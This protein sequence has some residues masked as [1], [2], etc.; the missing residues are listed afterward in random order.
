MGLQASTAQIQEGRT[1]T[2]T[3]PE[4]DTA[5]RRR[6]VGIALMCG[7]VAFFASLDACAKT[8]AR[9]GVDPL[10]TTFMRYAASVAMISLFINPVATPG[11]MK[12]RR[13]GL[14]IVRSL[15]LFASTALNFVALRYLQMAETISIQFAA[16]LTVAL[17]AGPLLGEWS[18]RARLA[19]IGVGF[20][21]VLVIVRPGVG[22]MHPAALLCVANVVVYAFYAILTRKL[23]AHDSTA[24]TMFYTG[25]AGVALMAPL[26]PWIW[27]NPSE[28][29][30]W[31]LLLGVALFGTLGHWLLVMAHARAPA[32]VLAPFIYTQ[33]LWSVT[34]GFL[35]FGDLPSRWTIVGAMIVVGSGLYLLAQDTL[36]R[37]ARR[38]AA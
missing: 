26:L 32:N 31:A 6:I 16:P 28:L 12:S 8:L 2:R 35:L 9:G 25:L 5:R 29:S 13:L 4:P 23:A 3:A 38:P 24:T 36:R 30:H 14:Q 37:E 1:E 18:S 27:A 22:T 21:G 20:L 34:L 7:A 17:L 11:V 19:A 15:L 10:V 33:L